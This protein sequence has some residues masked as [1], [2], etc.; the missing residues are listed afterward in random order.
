VPDRLT[1]ATLVS[2]LLRRVSAE[3]GNAVV[4][5]RGDATAGSIL[6]IC[7]EKGAR[8][9]LRERILGGDGRYRWAA[10]GPDAAA[11]EADVASW[12]ARRRSRDPDLWI[13]ELDIPNAER[14]AAETSGDD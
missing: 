9:A 5:A 14:F 2:A 3:G 4:V 1:S 7:L 13:V 12:L 8:T 10:V 11:D 6:L